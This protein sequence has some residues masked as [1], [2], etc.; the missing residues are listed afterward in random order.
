MAKYSA[1]L[2][3]FTLASLFRD[4]IVPLTGGL[5]FNELNRFNKV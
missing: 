1:W 2:T 4:P 3:F 5:C